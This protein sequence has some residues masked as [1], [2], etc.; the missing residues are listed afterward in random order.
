[1][2]QPSL[3]FLVPLPHLSSEAASSEA[4]ILPTV[5]APRRRPFDSPPGRPASGLSGPG[6]LLQ[7][8][9]IR[10]QKMALQKSPWA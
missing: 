1:M 4:C 3:S 7:G 6:R 10:L 5:L 9:G 8:Q 2:L